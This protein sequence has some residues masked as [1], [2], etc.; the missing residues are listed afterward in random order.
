MAKLK[1]I[2]V[3]AESAFGEAEI[4]YKL[5]MSRPRSSENG[6]IWDLNIVP[7]PHPRGEC[8]RHVIGFCPY[9][10]HMNYLRAVRR[11]SLVSANRS[12]EGE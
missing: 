4:E 9:A 12:S 6:V 5:D 2:F 7:K 10:T 1:N 8:P 11:A 3:K